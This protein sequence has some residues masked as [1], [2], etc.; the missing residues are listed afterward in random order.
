MTSSPLECSAR[1]WSWSQPARRD[2]RTTF[3]RRTGGPPSSPA[4]PP[5]HS[6]GASASPSV[7]EAVQ[8]PASARYGRIQPRPDGDARRRLG[9]HARSMDGRRADASR[10]AGLRRR[11]LGDGTVLAVGSDF[12]CQP[13]GAHSGSE[14]AEVY[15]P[16]VGTWTATASLNKPRKSFAT[17]VMPDGDALVL[18][19]ASIRMTTRTPARSSTRRTRIRGRQPHWIAPSL[20]HWPS[21]CEMAAC[22][23]MAPPPTAH[24]SRSSIRTPRTGWSHHR[25]RLSSMCEPWSESTEGA[26]AG[27]RHQ[28]RGRRRGEEGAATPTAAIY[29]PVTIGGR[30]LPVPITGPAEV[31]R[32]R[33]RG[34]AGDPWLRTGRRDGPRRTLRRRVRQVAL[35]RTDASR[36]RRP[37]SSP[38]TTV[39]YWSPAA[40][41]SNLVAGRHGPAARRHLRSRDRP[42]VAGGRPP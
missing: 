8:D 29:E 36:S 1:S 15:D 14:A 11:V 18:G 41:R 35:G 6:I 12:A 5:S 13:G 10:A 31:R 32:D 21:A 19:G 20:N 7:V 26:R 17:L 23:S 42:L 3:D 28:L 39:E 24:R 34:R 37:R 9:G 22:S 25:R 16:N 2:D 33:G 4:S 30:P 38:W 27:H 40:S